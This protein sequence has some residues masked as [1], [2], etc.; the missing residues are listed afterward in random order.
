MDVVH[1]QVRTGGILPTCKMS[2]MSR[3][4]KLEERIAQLEALVAQQ[5]AI[6]DELRAENQ[7]LR[8]E[9]AEQAETIR[10]LLHWRF[11]RRTEKSADLE[12][13]QEVIALEGWCSDLLG[14]EL[15]PLFAA[16]DAD[17]TATDTPMSAPAKPAGKK[18]HAR[19]LW[20]RLCPHLR[21]DEELIELPQNAQ[22][23]ADGTPLVRMGTE[24]RE[25]LV[26]EPGIPFIRRVVRQRYGRSDTAE[27]VVIAE[28]P[29]RIVPRG[30]LA[31][32]TILGAVVNLASDCLPFYR[33]AE[34]FERLGIPVTRQTL[35]ASFHAWCHVA[36]PMVDAIESQILAADCIHADGSFIYRQN[37]D[38]SRSCTRYPIYA[39]SDGNQVVYRWRADEKQA[40]AADLLRGYHGYLVRDE[41]GGWWKQHDAEITHVGC[42]AHA[43]RPF[44]KL[45]DKD[46]DAAKIVALYAQLAVVE[47]RAAASMLSGEALF[48]HRLRL[49]QQHSLPIMN[50]I[51]TQAKRILSSTRTGTIRTGANYIIKH[52]TELRRFLDNG[53][54]P[55]DNNLAERVLRR[56]AIIRRNRP[57]YVADDG[58][59]NLAHALSICGS[60]RQLGVNPAAYLKHSLPALLAY[61]TARTNGQPLPSLNEWTPS[62]YA[63]NASRAAAA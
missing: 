37:R 11:G 39:I 23:D 5:A 12:K 6:I 56:N 10:G 63:A 13:L 8:A 45:Q 19:Q 52:R 32:E 36:S 17:E 44:A 18:K 59:I 55:P 40:S 53:A 9:N 30:A 61:R 43:R 57:F 28:N 3:V 22:F 1:N 2:V 48:A 33:Q 42:N 50:A 41:W 51:E 21:I 58:G 47:K 20:S 31:D 49:R 54:L 35:C 25:E 27:K 4:R 34:M 14:H 16:D 62:A 46:A 7:R 60:C 29:D 26:Y 38:G 24:T 15:E